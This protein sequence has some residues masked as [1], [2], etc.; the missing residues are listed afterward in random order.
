MGRPWTVLCF[1]RHEIR[2][3]YSACLDI[4]LLLVMSMFFLFVVSEGSSINDVVSHQL[5]FLFTFLSV[6]TTASRGKSAT[7]FNRKRAY[8]LQLLVCLVQRRLMIIH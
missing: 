2:L 4:L 7:E 6:S 1:L 8:A 3:L 5:V